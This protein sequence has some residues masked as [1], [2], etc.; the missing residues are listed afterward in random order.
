MILM[1]D[2]CV[3]SSDIEPYFDSKIIFLAAINRLTYSYC[4]R[5]QF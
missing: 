4:D 5:M 3:K 2:E 1:N